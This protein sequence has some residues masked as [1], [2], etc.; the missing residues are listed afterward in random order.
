MYKKA[1]GFVAAGAALVGL[2]VA[3]SAFAATP[4]FSA[5]YTGNS[6][7]VQVNITNADPNYGVILNYNSQMRALG[8]A[9]G[10]GSFSATISTSQYGITPGAVVSVTVD[11][12][13]SSA[14]QWPYTTTSSNGAFS[15]SQTNVSLSVGQTSVITA[16]VS[17]TFY[18]SSNSN[19]SVANV[20]LN[21]NQF[22]ISANAAGTTNLTICMVANSAYCATA[23]VTV[24]GAS[25]QTLTFS[26]NNLSLPYGQNATVIVSGGTG[27]YAITSNTNSASIQATVSNSVVSLYAGNVSGS[28]VITVCSTNMTSCGVIY[29][30]AGASS[31]YTALSFSQTNPTLA[32]GQAATISVTGGVAPYYISA[33]SNTAAVQTSVSGNVVTLS[34]MIA[35]SATVTVCSATNICGTITATVGSS[36]GSVTFAQN[37]VTLTQGQSLTIGLSGSSSYYIASNANASVASAAVSGTNVV[38]GANAVGTDNV[39]VCGSSGQCATLFVN[40]AS[41]GSAASTAS[42]LSP[43][44]TQVLS[45]GQG[46]NLMLSGGV[47]PYY[48]SSSTSPVFTAVLNAGNVLTLTGVESGVSSLNVCAAGGYCAPVNVAVVPGTLS[49]SASSA[50]SSSAGSSGG[51]VFTTFLSF[52]DRSAAVTQLQ[53]KLK[54]LGVYSGPITGYYGDQTT[55]AVKKFQSQHGINAVGYVGPSTRAA[56]N[57][58]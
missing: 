41:N 52:G 45:V 27:I 9:D 46:I 37:N 12:K 15:L 53:T 3:A 34:G 54:S 23:T 25:N 55:A 40:V 33:N 36:S 48:L 13:T 8:T 35:G 17:G 10:S 39:S 31:S 51:Y 7:Y 2:F 24:S 28:A 47:T 5:F 20:S 49:S 19:P 32:I 21:S 42:G 44:L 16:N 22:T 58:G 6:D 50:P 18:L 4:S 43:T 26:Q 30:T 56:L 1:V 38:V 29:A 11:G 14:I 57:G